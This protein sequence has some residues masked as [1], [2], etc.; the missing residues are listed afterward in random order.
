VAANV[1]DTSDASYLATT[2]RM[3]GGAPETV[4]DK[5]DA[6]YSELTKIYNF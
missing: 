4:S 5:K 3:M 1:A 6:K 2:S